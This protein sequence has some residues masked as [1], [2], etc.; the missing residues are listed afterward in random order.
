MLHHGI[1]HQCKLS[2][3]PPR[4]AAGRGS[5]R[6]PRQITDSGIVFSSRVSDP[7]Q[8]A[9]D[10]ELAAAEAEA[11]GGVPGYCSDPAYKAYAGGQY[12]P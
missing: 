11:Q 7:S 1:T 10:D 5:V 9:D 6:V 3:E 12:C 4:Y 8:L 2:S